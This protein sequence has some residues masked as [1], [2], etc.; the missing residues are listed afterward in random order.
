MPE[1]SA[2]Y[3]RNAGLSR[4]AASWTKSASRRSVTPCSARYSLRQAAMAAV[5]FSWSYSETSAANSYPWTR[6]DLFV[7][8]S[9]LFNAHKIKKPIL[10]THGTADTNVPVGESIQMY[11]A[12]RLLGVPTAFV[13][14]EGENHGIMDPTKRTRWINTMVAWFDRYLKGDSSWWNAIYS[15]KKL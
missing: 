12:L 10:F 5:V 11:T 1:K 9:P 2:V 13:E 4:N 8:R 7:D 14:V 3:K 6:K 15:P